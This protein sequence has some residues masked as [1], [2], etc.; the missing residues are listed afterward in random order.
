MLLLFR[1]TFRE[2]NHTFEVYD[3]NEYLKWASSYLLQ[4][5]IQ[6]SSKLHLFDPQLNMLI[7]A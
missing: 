5:K 7:G 6:N 2:I 1:K 3:C 4:Q